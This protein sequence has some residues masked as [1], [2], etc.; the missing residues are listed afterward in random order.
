MNKKHKC[1][2]FVQFLRHKRKRKINNSR[3]HESASNQ[4]NFSM[5]FNHSAFDACLPMREK[6]NINVHFAAI[7]SV[8]LFCNLYLAAKGIF[9][10]SIN[11][12]NELF[13]ARKNS[14][15]G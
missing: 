3:M 5:R 14:L 15:V 11:T 6:I 10:Q 9:R 12:R 2:E 4:V 13:M 1:D 8:S 7:A